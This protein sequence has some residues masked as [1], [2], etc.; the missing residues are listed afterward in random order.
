VQT[1]DW[2]LLVIQV[3]HAAVARQPVH[4]KYDVPLSVW[5][6]AVSKYGIETDTVLCKIMAIINVGQI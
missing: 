2:P 6:I 3:K 5:L 4:D 1:A